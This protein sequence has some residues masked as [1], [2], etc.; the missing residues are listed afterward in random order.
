[1]LVIVDPEDE[2]FDRDEKICQNFSENKL[3]L[4]LPAIE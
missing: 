1:M 2:E 3:I 4:T